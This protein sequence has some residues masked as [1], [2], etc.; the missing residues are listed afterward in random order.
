MTDADTAAPMLQQRRWRLT[1]R[2][3]SCAKSA[4][5]ACKS[6]VSR[7]VMAR[8]LSASRAFVQMLRWARQKWAHGKMAKADLRK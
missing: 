4:A 7:A 1:A 3:S 8:V 6:F 5:W 2:A